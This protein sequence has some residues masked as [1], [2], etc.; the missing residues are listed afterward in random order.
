VASALVVAAWGF[1]LIMGV[2]DPE[3][4]VKALWPIFGIA[5][6][7]LASI[8]LCL[9]TTILLKMQL[10]RGRSPALIAVTLLPLIWLLTVTSTAAIQKVWHENPRIGFLAA[11]K[12]AEAKIPA[13]QEKLTIAQRGTKSVAIYEAEK[14]LKSTRT[15]RF[16][17]TIDA[18][19]AGGFLALVAI[20]VVL[21]IREWMLLIGGRR[22]PK[23]SE[24]EPVWLSPD[25]LANERPVQMMGMAVLGFT[26]IKELSGQ[27]AIDREQVRAEQCD[28]VEAKTVRGRQNVFLTATERRFTGINRC[29]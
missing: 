8:A 2:R 29:C 26:L 11:A 7:L 15:I 12:A 23:L 21:S 4:G 14:A 20:I 24:T 13:L 28:C 1:F 27:A 18:Y 16:N 6:Q 5:N 17:N 10:N 25:V 3:G 19:V 9:C 22:E